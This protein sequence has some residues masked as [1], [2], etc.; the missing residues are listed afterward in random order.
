MK[1][2]IV[3]FDGHNMLFRYFWGMPN[4]ILSKEGEPIH[5]AYGFIS[6]ILKHLR[7]FLPVSAI[8]CFDSE[9]EPDR[10]QS[11][12]SYKENRIWN[13]PT[14]SRLN[15]F[16]QYPLIQHALD[17]LNI[18]WI[19][20][21]G[22]EADDLIGSYSRIAKNKGFSVIIASTDADYFQLIDDN[23]YVYFQRGKKETLCS[24][25]WVM[26]RYNIA[27][28]QIIDFKA[29]SGDV[30]D[31]ISGVP[32]IGP[33]R[34]ALLLSQFGSVQDIFENLENIPKQMTKLLE[35]YKDNV[36][37]NIE[38]IKINT[39]I[40]VNEDLLRELPFCD[41]STRQLFIKMGI[42]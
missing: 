41:I 1:K 2:N 27:P 14:D 15:P 20:K 35:P 13:F 34:A 5:A 11:M 28:T 22:I 12:L 4:R 16:S 39:G 6:S 23:V 40:D 3:L 36:L 37:A 7:Q 42:W 30:S 21:P 38:I 24:P 25:A 17:Y 33:K 9:G 19:E 31:S 8:V 29:L 18:P 26:E 10:T 32:G